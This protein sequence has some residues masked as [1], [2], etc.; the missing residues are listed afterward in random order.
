MPLD[1]E[2]GVFGMLHRLVDAVGCLS[3][4]NKSGG[5]VADGLVVERVDGDG[6]S[7]CRRVEPHRALQFRV[8]SGEG[9]GLRDD[10]A[11]FLLTMW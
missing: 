6:R 9:D 11:R 2:D 1:A 4:G 7:A 10:V 8:R 5:K 3:R